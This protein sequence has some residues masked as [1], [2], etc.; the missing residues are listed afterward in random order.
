MKSRGQNGFVGLIVGLLCATW[1][2]AGQSI[3]YVYLGKDTSGTENMLN[4]KVIGE[5]LGKLG[6]SPQGPITRR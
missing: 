4:A 3:A 1:A 2:C 6:A 5:G